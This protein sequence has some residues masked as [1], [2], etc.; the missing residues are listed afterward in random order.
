[1]LTGAWELYLNN[2]AIQVHFWVDVSGSVAWQIWKFV[3]VK[4]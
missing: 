3:P 1:M 4:L 2:F